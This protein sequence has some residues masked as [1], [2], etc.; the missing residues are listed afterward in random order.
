ME[1]T[2]ARTAFIAK[3]SKQL[4]ESSLRDEPIFDF[5]KQFGEFATVISARGS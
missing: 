4:F 1:L 3:L 2:A 5:M